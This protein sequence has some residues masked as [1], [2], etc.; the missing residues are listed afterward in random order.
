MRL[1]HGICGAS[2]GACRYQSKKPLVAAL[3]SGVICDTRFG[4]TAGSGRSYFVS[5]ISALLQPR[6]SQCGGR[7]TKLGPFESANMRLT[8]PQVSS[9]SRPEIHAT[10]HTYVFLINM[11]CISICVFRATPQLMEYCSP[12][13]F[14]STIAITR[15]IA[16]LYIS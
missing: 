13:N 6:I 8:A 15:S 10:M 3:R 2:R 9:Y 7:M 16:W 4:S 14:S 12:V 5:I 11:I 1:W